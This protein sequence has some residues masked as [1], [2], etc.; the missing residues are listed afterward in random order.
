MDYRKLIRKKETRRKLLHLLSFIP[1]RTMIKLQFNIMTGRKLNLREPRSFTEKLQWYKLYYRDPLMKQC[2]DK[3]DVRKYVQ[4]KGL[5]EILNNLYGV[6]DS[7]E[8]V[9]FNEL[10]AQFVLKATNGSGGQNVLFCK[11]K[12]RFDTG[13]NRILLKQWI[14][15]T[16]YKSSGREWCYYHAKPRIIAER[17]L[18]NE[19]NPDAGIADYKFFCFDGIPMYVVVDVDR[20]IGHKRNF[21]DTDWKQIQVSS[22]C[23]NFPDPLPKPEELGNMISVAAALSSEFPFVRVDLYNVS[24]RIY[25]GELTFYPWSG[26]VNFVPDDF[27]YDLGKEFVLPKKKM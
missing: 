14:Q 6:Y 19:Q 11:D 20:F 18:I 13:V 1:D 15:R 9:D 23:P 21:Y 8:D 10:P 16:R 4:S 17:L 24:G 3:Y 12:S 2:A 22:D 26:Y 5:G 27:D 7:F 25:F